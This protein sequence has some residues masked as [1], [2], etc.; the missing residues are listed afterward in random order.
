MT[1][2]LNLLPH[3]KRCAHLESL[4]TCRAASR[5]AGTRRFSPSC[6]TCGRR[7]STS[8]ILEQLDIDRLTMV[9]SLTLRGSGVNARGR[10]PA[11]RRVAQPDGVLRL[12]RAHV[13]LSATRI[14]SIWQRL[15]SL[16]ELDLGD[17]GS[18]WRWSGPPG[19]IE[20]PQNTLLWREGI[21]R[22]PVAHREVDQSHGARPLGHGDHGCWDGPYRQTDGP[23]DTSA[24]WHEDHQRRNRSTEAP[25]ESQGA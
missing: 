14:S 3:W 25:E 10:S 12:C 2:L 4:S 21:R 22:R 15:G 24:Q 8:A 23:E 13:P 6:P 11:T 17:T 20:E 9:E 16:E 1:I 7:T 5:K 18:C 19:G